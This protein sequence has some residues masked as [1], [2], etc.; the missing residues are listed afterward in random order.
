MLI[1]IELYR[2]DDAKLKQCSLEALSR[3]FKVVAHNFAAKIK[4]FKQC[5]KAKKH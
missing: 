2:D 5:M 3:Y 1:K 4:L